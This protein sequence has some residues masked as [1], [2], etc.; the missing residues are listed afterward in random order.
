[1]KKHTVLIADDSP[2]N[3]QLLLDILSR[4]GFEVLA[5][6]K[7][8]EVLEIIEEET[9]DIFLLD[10]M[11]PQM[12]GF[13]LCRRLKENPRFQATPIIFITAKNT[14][15]DIVSGFAAGAVD[16]I[17]KPFNE[18]EILARVRTHIH[19]HEV[20]ME[21]ER[22][23]QLALDANPLTQL[24]GNNSIIKAINEAIAA[25]QDVSVAYV[26]LDNFKALNDKYGFAV[27]DRVLLYTARIIGTAV[28]EICG[29]GN[30]IGHIGGDDFVFI[31]SSD[32]VQKVAERIIR[33]F[34]ANICQ[35]YEP[36]DLARQAIEVADRSGN[37]RR[38]P[39]ATISLG[40]VELGEKNFS[41]HLEVSSMCAEVKKMA[42]DMPGS[43]C[44]FNRRGMKGTLRPGRIPD[45]PPQ[46][47][48]SVF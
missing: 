47:E 29:K 6:E 4:S 25:E 35:F 27:G 32:L 40:I 19:L 10:V 12:D 33:E 1:M 44:F 38:F 8:Q 2:S 15:A 45:S 16:Y 18:A 11:M 28:E 14:S 46:G 48:E 13:S 7:G 5:A 21:L 41:H 23:R 42:K 31:V 43:T 20:V 39:L 36:R 22:L 30:M 34:D 3:L 24:P 17:L 26:D 9:P 37:Q